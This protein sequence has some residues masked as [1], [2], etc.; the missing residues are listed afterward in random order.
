VTAHSRQPHCAGCGRPTPTR[1]ML[2]LGDGRGYCPRCADRLPP[3]VRRR[4]VRTAAARGEQA[5][6]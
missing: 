5:A 4:A 2:P 3:G 1:R 6:Q